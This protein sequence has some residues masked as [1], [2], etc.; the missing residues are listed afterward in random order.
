[1][2]TDASQLTWPDIKLTDNDSRADCQKVNHFEQRI[3]RKVLFTAQ[4]SIKSPQVNE[5]SKV[6]NERN[7]TNVLDT[8]RFSRYIKQSIMLVFTPV[9]MSRAASQ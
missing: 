8:N 2:V 7:K 9:C 1:M 6:V 4:H 3:E 5:L